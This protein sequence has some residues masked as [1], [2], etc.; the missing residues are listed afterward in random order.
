MLVI[1]CSTWAFAGYKNSKN[2][3]NGVIMGTWGTNAGNV[4]SRATHLYILPVIEMLKFFV[5]NL[6]ANYG[7][8]SLT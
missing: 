3:I 8:T 4:I 2:V 1:K 5:I 7:V 6:P